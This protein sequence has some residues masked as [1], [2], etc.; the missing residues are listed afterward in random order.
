MVGQVFL[1]S[2]ALPALRRGRPFGMADA[3][4]SLDGLSSL[5]ENYARFETI[6]EN[7]IDPTVNRGMDIFEN[8][9]RPQIYFWLLLTTAGTVIGGAIVNGAISG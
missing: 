7:Q 2:L 6:Y 3:A 1:L 9:T 8:F 5:D 4:G